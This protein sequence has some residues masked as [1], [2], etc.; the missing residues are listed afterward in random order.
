MEPK[1]ETNDNAAGQ[2]AGLQF[3]LR[4]SKPATRKVGGKTITVQRVRASRATH[5]RR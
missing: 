1:P 3:D 4:N 5:E 2:G